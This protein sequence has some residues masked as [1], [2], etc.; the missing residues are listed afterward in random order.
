MERKVLVIGTD[1]EQRNIGSAIAAFLQSTSYGKV[2][3]VPYRDGHDMP[4]EKDMTGY[5]DIVVACGYMKIEPFDELKPDDL[6]TIIDACLTIPLWAVQNFVRATKNNR[7]QPKGIVLIGS[8]A[9]NHV[10]SNSVP[11]CAAKAGIDMAVKG[12]AWELTGQK[13]N[14]F[15]VHP[16]SVQDTPMT[17]R[18]IEQI[19]HNKILTREQAIDYWQKDMRLGSRLTRHEIARTVYMLLTPPTRH[20]SGACL[21][22]YGGER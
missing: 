11:Y 19:M 4:S 16:H 21:E 10:L 5:T 1:Q 12:L 6:F 13:Y 17:D 8:Y 14:V 3:G 9:H 18:V 20:L 7:V 22:L 2:V 15:G